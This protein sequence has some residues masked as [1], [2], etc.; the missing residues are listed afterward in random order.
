MVHAQEGSVLHLCTK[1]KADMSIRSKVIGWSQ[2]FEIG[3][4]TLNHA[5]FEPEHC[6]CVEIHLYYQSLCSSL[7]RC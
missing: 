3:H 4:V 6:I 2:N 5:P 1:L 7:I